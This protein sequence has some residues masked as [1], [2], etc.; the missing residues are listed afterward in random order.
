MPNWVTGDIYIAGKG[1]ALEYL[2]DKE[3]TE[4]KFIY[5]EKLQER[6][7]RTGDVGRYMPDR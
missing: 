1:L 3:L 4:K 5:S 2:G 7:Y 6:L